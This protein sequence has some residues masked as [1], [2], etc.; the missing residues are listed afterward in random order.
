LHSQINRKTIFKTLET[1]LQEFINNTK[2]T[3]VNYSEEERINGALI[4]VR[5][6]AENNRF[7]RKFPVVCVQTGL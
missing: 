5:V 4:F 3:E 6:I 7:Q 2:W 1:S